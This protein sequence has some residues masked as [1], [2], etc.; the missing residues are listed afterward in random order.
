VGTPYGGTRYTWGATPTDHRFTDQTEIASIGLYDYGARMYSPSLGRFIS[1]DTIVPSP[2]NPQS[3][4][5]YSYVL[6]NPLKYKDPTGH[7][8][9][10]NDAGVCVDDNYSTS[11]PSFVSYDTNERRKR[12]LDY[13]NSLYEWAKR[14]WITD[15]EAF[16]Q[17][18]DYAAS[19]IPK[20]VPGNRTAIFV[21]D[22]ASIVTELEGKE[23]Y[24]E[25]KP[26]GQTGFD[27]VFQDPSTGGV[28]P[29][30]FWAFVTFVFH[31]RSRTIAT[32]GNLA[33]ETVVAS[34]GKGRSYQD[35]A[36]GEEGVNL[37]VKLKRGE[38]KIEQVGDYMR[39]HLKPGG[40]AVNTWNGT[41]LAHYNKM[42]YALSLATAAQLVPIPLGEQGGLR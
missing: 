1:A 33:H 8:I 20:D 3:L 36:L 30:H 2:G 18:S 42:L 19:M 10:C 27:W 32:L 39:S 13:N 28:Q 12:L 24:G 38:V 21:K 23:Y 11:N 4:N 16:A 15:L 41:L 31:Y 6:G 5:R 7:F 17:L 22:L 37:G 26:L 14:G 29:H 34:D 25:A 9:Q 40:A 35:Y